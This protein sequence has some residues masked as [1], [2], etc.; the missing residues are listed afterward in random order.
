MV[1]LDPS[2][3]DSIDFSASINRIKN[4]VLTDFILASHYSVIYSSSPDELQEC[5]KNL[6]RTGDYAPE[7]LIKMDIPKSTGLT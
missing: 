5:T 2:L 6:L 4:D 1:G 3:V 7:L